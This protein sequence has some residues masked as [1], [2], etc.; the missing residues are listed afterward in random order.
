MAKEIIIMPT[1]DN[2][3]WAKFLDELC[4]TNSSFQFSYERTDEKW[5]KKAA[6]NKLKREKG[7]KRTWKRTVKRKDDERKNGKKD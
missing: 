4:H 6:G 1:D 7:A 5:K 2:E 3:I